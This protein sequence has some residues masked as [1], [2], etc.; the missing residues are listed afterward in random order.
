MRCS[1]GDTR[2]ASY[3]AGDTKK[4]RLDGCQASSPPSSRSACRASL[5]RSGGDR[6][7]GPSPRNDRPAGEGCQ[8]VAAPAPAPLATP[9]PAGE[10]PPAPAPRQPCAMDRLESVSPQRQLLAGSRQSDQWDG[11]PQSLQ[12]CRLSLCFDARSYEAPL[13]C[14][15]FASDNTHSSVVRKPL[16][17]TLQRRGRPSLTK[18]DSSAT[19]AEFALRDSSRFKPSRTD[20]VACCPSFACDGLSSVRP[21]GN[22]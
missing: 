1:R 5:A 12:S 21:A 19:A 20:V 9:E 15:L 7:I 2:C 3:I 13:P 10:H 17:V 16:D 11:W 6:M 22:A 14:L 4:G 18:P 8:A